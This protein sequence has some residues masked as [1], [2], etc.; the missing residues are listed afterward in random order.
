MN[1]TTG[2]RWPA[3]I[4]AGIGLLVVGVAIGT[5]FPSAPSPPANSPPGNSPPDMAGMPAGHDTT[6]PDTPS[7]PN[8][9]L[10]PDMVD[11]AGI[12]TVL[13]STT[14]M[15]GEIRIPGRVQPNTY[16][17][18]VVTSLVS[19]RVLAA[20]AQ[21]GD[22]VSPGQT[23]ATVYGPELAEA[24]AE[25]LGLQADFAAHDQR[26][27][28]S[29]RLGS[30]GAV[31]RQEVD[32]VE[33]GHTRMRTALEGAKSR[34][35]LLGM[36]EAAVSRLSDDGKVTAALNI[37]APLVGTVLERNANPGANIDTSTPLFKVA[38]LSTVWIIGDLYERDL[39]SVSLGMP[40]TIGSAA[41][42][43][44]TIEGTVSYIDPQV[45][46]NTRTTQVR[47]EA[48]NRDGRLR[49]GMLVDV[50]LDT[51][52]S[53]SAL[54]VPR[55]AVQVRGATSVVYVATEHAGHFIEREI[56][57]GRQNANAV[58]VM[59]GL[60]PGERVV[61]TGAFFLR[62]ERERTAGTPGGAPAA[63]QH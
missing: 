23:L 33:A 6:A 58:E 59:H 8:I 5:T 25:Y 11:R 42:P 16:R 19:G 49:L 3:A 35:L 29:L 52:L 2:L 14:Q 57:V 26:L 24:Q 27:A 31:S 51:G 50:T 1:G 15:G 48:P 18:V 38:D 61:T 44:T 46:Q 55:A 7:D 40:A 36:T 41:Y 63:H 37:P 20:P 10:T 22:R 13:V 53:S 56:H 34:L 54:I 39:G 28:R 47:I 9:M 43:D 12:E 4:V 21:L 30:I 60:E 32:E 17:E 45:Q 62:A